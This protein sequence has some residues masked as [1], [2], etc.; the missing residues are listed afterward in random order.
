MVRAE[1]RRRVLARQFGLAVPGGQVGPGAVEVLVTRLPPG[2][3]PVEVLV[4][5]WSPVP[6]LF[7]VT[8]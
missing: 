2:P 4:A 7:A 6:G 1:V 3:G 8:E 5:G